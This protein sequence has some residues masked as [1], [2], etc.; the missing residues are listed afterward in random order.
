[1]GRAFH[2][3]LADVPRPMFLDRREDCWA[4]GDRVAWQEAEVDIVPALREPY[5]ALTAFLGPR[6]ADRSQLVHGDLTGNV[7]FAPGLALAVIDFSPYWRPPAFGEAVVVADAVLWH[8]AGAG[9][10]GDVVDDSGPG[11]LQYVARALLFRLVTASERG[12]ARASRIGGRRPFSPA[13]PDLSR[14]VGGRRGDLR[15]HAGSVSSTPSTKWSNSPAWTPSTNASHFRRFVV[16]T[17]SGSL[18]SRR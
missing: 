3:A 6:P 14:L 16:T 9:L 13:L 18:V 4:V 15:G 5:R 8:G 12:R 1:M 2:R 11:F 17:F 10:L 7:L